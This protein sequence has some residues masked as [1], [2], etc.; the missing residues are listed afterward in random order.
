VTTDESFFIAHS[1]PDEE[2]DLHTT[3][4]NPSSAP[5]EADLARVG[6][7]SAPSGPNLTQRRKG[8]EENYLR[9]EPADSISKFP[10]IYVVLRLCGS[11]PLGEL[12]DPD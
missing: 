10:Q 1:S 3:R 7:F 12:L 2:G 9:S 6:F 5:F 8:A 4:R 11:T